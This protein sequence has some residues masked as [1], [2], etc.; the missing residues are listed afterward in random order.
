V[1]VQLGQVLEAQREAPHRTR[2]D[3]V[4]AR[5]LP[6]Q[7][8]E[9]L[10]GPVGHMLTGFQGIVSA[11]SAYICSEVH[12]ENPTSSVLCSCGVRS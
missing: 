2:Y 8:L 1:T 10:S 7:T 4:L 3:L 6:F 11:A 9:F 5:E 12:G